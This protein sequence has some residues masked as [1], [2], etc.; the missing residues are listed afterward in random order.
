MQKFSALRGAF[1]LGASLVT[2]STAHAQSAK[3][4]GS[5]E[6]PGIVGTTGV[7][8]NAPPPN[9]LLDNGVNITGVGQMRTITNLTT[10]V[11]F[12][13]SGTLINPRTVIFAAHC[14]N[15]QAA[16]TYGY[17]TGGTPISFGF[18]ADNA[19]ARRLWAGLSADGLT[20]NPIDAN[21]FQ[22]NVGNAI[23]SGEHVWYDPRSLLPANAG[24]INSDLALVTLDTPAND[25]PTWAMLFTPLTSPTHGV[26]N[27][28]GATGTSGTSGANLGVDSRRRIAENMIDF[29]V[30]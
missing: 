7:N 16:N 9:G 18:Q 8:P 28:Y 12:V 27:G 30:S 21:T 1:L 22:T 24:F 29:L 17:N 5:E 6:S 11:G 3:P 13:C 26:I 4:V 15:G 25:I 14:V 10:R 20:R 2:L 19:V 23:Y